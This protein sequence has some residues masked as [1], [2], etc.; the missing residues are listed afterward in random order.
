M[1]SGQLNLQMTWI[2]MEGYRFI[3]LCGSTGQ[4]SEF[5]FRVNL[6]DGLFVSNFFKDKI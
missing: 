6:V 4:V 3:R 1:I 5:G 2:D